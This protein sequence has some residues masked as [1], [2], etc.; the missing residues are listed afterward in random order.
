MKMKPKPCLEPRFLDIS[1]FLPS[2]ALLG[3]LLSGSGSAWAASVQA[4]MSDSFADSAGINI[5]LR[6][7]DTTYGLYDARVKPRLLELG[8]RH[9]RDGYDGN[10][11]KFESKVLDLGNAGIKSTLVWHGAPQATVIAAL[12]SLRPALQAVE[13]PN[14]SDLPM[15]GFSYNGQGFPLGTRAYQRDLY[16]WIKGD[17]TLS[18]LPVIQASMGWGRNAVTYGNQGS[19]ADRACGHFYTAWGEAPGLKLDE[20]HL[21]YADLPTPGK[22]KIV[23]ESGYHTAIRDSGRGGISEWA[24]GRYVS[25]IFT[26]HFRRGI[27]RTFIYELLEQRNDPDTV[28]ESHYGLVRYDNTVKPSFTAMKNLILL[29]NDKGSTFTPQS[30][31]YVFSGGN[32][33]LRHFLLQKRNGTFQIVVWQDPNNYNVDLL[34]DIVVPDQKVTLTL[35]GKSGTINT[36]LPM[37]GTGSSTLTLQNS[38][39]TVSVPDHPMIIELGSSSPA[40]GTISRQVWNNVNGAT[41]ATIPVNTTPSSSGTLT[42]FE[43]PTNVADNYGQ[44]VRGYLT[45][46]TTGSYTFWVA[47]DDNCELYLSTDDQASRVVKIAS[48]TDW[49]G[50]REWNKYPTQ[51]SA[52][53]S[54]VAGQQYYVEALMKEGGG[55]DNLAVGWAKPDQSTTS[56]SEVIPGSALSPTTGT[57]SHQV[58]NNV[59]GT[60]VSTI[61]VNTTPSSTGTLTS[62]E[63]PTNVANNYGQR[64]RGYLT[65]PTTGNYTFWVAGD[66]HCELYL[67]TNDQEGSIV[68]I[69][70]HTDWTDSREWNKYPTQKS[71]A[72][73]LIAGQQY[74]V[75]A[76]MKE[77]GG[78]D[79]LAVG[80]AKPDQSTTSPS[81]VIPG[82]ALSPYNTGRIL[83][84]VWNNVNGEAV[85][86]IPVNTTPSSTGTLTSFEAPTDVAENYGQRVRGYLTAPTTGSYTF[87]VASDDHCEL[88]LS[89]NDQAISKVKIASH[90]DWT[91]SREWNKYP[92][93]K[94]AAIS[95]VAGQ[96]YYVEALMKEGGAGD[97]FA[98]AWAKPGQSATSPSEVIPGGNLSREIQP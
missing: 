81:G 64:V 35:I 4:K 75:E 82:S 86:A 8:V 67:S 30:L 31:D 88:Y 72:I 66:D 54:L 24:Q 11:L 52:A 91:N 21:P 33:L 97:N 61:P 57:I 22:T 65:A 9:V 68:K 19:S 59:N 28:S 76:L 12:K 7:L 3:S 14:E 20:W 29:T 56:P 60:M 6:Y 23:T 15:M 71:A 87:W 53:I 10:D 16:S 32:A 98:V 96:Q 26:E 48:H 47:G 2:L 63:A 1:K 78:G 13:G 5:H 34:Q 90:T 77:G 43:A 17:A 85:S 70:S 58:W 50:S 40:T 93:Q 18:S 73:S 36:Y 37:S 45:A 92:T 55:G 46:P 51:K 80:W 41:V 44:R 25:R 84:E 42:S 94:S 95:L 79:N 69:A 27:E 38:A 74:Y 39:V 62:F 49:T 89:T 83:R